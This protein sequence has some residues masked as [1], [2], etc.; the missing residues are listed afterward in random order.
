MIAIHLR[1]GGPPSAK[2]DPRSKEKSVGSGRYTRHKL[3]AYMTTK[4]YSLPTEAAKSWHGGKLDY[5]NVLDKNGET[6]AEIIYGTVAKPG[7]LPPEIYHVTT[8][9]PAV[10]Q[11]GYLKGQFGENQGGLGGGIRPMV[12]LTTSIGDARLI[13]NELV[14]M[15]DFAQGRLTV[16]DLPRIAQQDTAMYHLSPEQTTKLDAMQSDVAR[17]Y[18][19]NEKWYKDNSSL[20]NLNVETFQNYLT[21]RESAGIENPLL[22]GKADSWKNLDVGRIGILKIPSANLF[23]SGGLVRYKITRSDYLH[24]VNVHGDVPIDGSEVVK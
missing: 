15:V 19:G 24:E 12:A 4:D 3:Q 20:R 7:D 9:L 6:T 23:K 22:L 2:P 1:E 18:S 8:N 10:E 21:Y 14:R 13:R 16:D 17:F 11:A 5:V